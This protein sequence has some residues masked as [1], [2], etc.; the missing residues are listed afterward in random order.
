MWFEGKLR[1]DVSGALIG[2]RLYNVLVA[3]VGVVAWVDSVQPP[4][5]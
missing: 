5:M 4:G 2:S 1:S 3:V